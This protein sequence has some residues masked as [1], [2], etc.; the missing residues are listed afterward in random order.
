[1]ILLILFISQSGILLS[2]LIFYR[3]HI[4]KD[5]VS[6]YLFMHNRGAD[7][8][9]LTPVLIQRL[10]I[11]HIKALFQL[12]TKFAKCDDTDLTLV[13]LLKAM[14]QPSLASQKKTKKQN[15]QTFKKVSILKWTRNITQLKCLSSASA[16]SQYLGYTT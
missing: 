2:N 13:I 16:I 5:R 3:I 4:L 8:A 6:K 7:H 9:L 12:G 14:W 10:M 11:L 1:M 15:A